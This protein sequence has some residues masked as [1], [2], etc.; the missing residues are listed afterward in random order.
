[1]IFNDEGHE[2]ILF[3]GTLKAHAIHHLL[4]YGGIPKIGKRNLDISW[5]AN[6]KFLPL[7]CFHM[8]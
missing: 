7:K 4:R 8:L 6:N 5:I 3:F 1:M 2:F